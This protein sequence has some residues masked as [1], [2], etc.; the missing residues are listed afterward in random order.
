MLD[1]NE[2]RTNIA[3]SVAAGLLTPAQAEALA[4]QAT[5]L[6]WQQEYWNA[7]RCESQSI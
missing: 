4:D 5:I 2:V 6:V 7:H 1:L 3:R